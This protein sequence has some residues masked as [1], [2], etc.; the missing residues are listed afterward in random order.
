[1]DL[2]WQLSEQKLCPPHLLFLCPLQG[3]FPRLRSG[4]SSVIWGKCCSAVP[5]QIGRPL[6]VSFV[7]GD[8]FQGQVF[9]RDRRLSRS[10]LHGATF[11]CRARCH[12]WGRAHEWVCAG[13]LCLIPSVTTASYVVLASVHRASLCICLPLQK[14]LGY[15]C[16]VYFSVSFRTSLSSAI[17]SPV[18]M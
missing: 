3:F 12:H 17:D 16:S 5:T 15:A 13:V 1:M 8:G 18:E 6:R 14:C 9:K 11:S 2:E 10:C 4:R 7:Y